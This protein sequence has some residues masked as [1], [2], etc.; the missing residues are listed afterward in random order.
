MNL[1]DLDT[2]RGLLG[3]LMLHP[4]RLPEAV[5]DRLAPS[6]F[7]APAH[8][9]AFAAMLRLGP[10]PILARPWGALV[11]E[12]RRTGD[13]AVAGGA[14]GLVDHLLAA[15]PPHLLRLAWERLLVLAAARRVQRVLREADAT[16][17]REPAR[18]REVLANIGGR[19]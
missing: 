3:G 16:V 7:A 12:L 18:A 10:D 9:V 5:A 8:T 13:L 1:A 14:V 2:E 17:V 4:D 6:S 11:D 19:A 15:L